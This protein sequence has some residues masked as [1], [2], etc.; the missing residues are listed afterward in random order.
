MAKWALVLAFGSTASA[1]LTGAGLPAAIVCPKLS[2]YDVGR[3]VLNE[4]VSALTITHGNSAK[5]PH[6]ST[7]KAGG[8]RQKVAQYR[9]PIAS[10][11]RT[12][13]RK[14]EMP[15]LEMKET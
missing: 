13:P 5:M 14:K 9:R 2:P 10:I 4:P 11:C 1:A 15:E 12:Q 3:D 7:R 6:H 8:L